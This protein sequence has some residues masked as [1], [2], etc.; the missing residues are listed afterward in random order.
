[1]GG[2]TK[3]DLSRSLDRLLAVGA[4]L[5]A[6]GAALGAAEAAVNRDDLALTA[7]RFSVLVGVRAAPG[8]SPVLSGLCGLFAVLHAVRM[9]T[10]SSWLCQISQQLSTA[11]PFFSSLVLS[12]LVPT[13]CSQKG[14]QHVNAPS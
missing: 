8:I 11:K 9:S 10:I 5:G 1:M 14:H 4:A 3:S 2:L 7:A 6:A 13:T 12:P